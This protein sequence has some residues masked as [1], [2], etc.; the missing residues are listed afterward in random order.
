M[1]NKKH[2]M[3]YVNCNQPLYVDVDD[4]CLKW[5][6][7]TNPSENRVKVECDGFVQYLTP[8]KENIRQLKAH[9]ARGHTVVVWSAGGSSWALAAVKALELESFVDLVTEK[10]MWLLD[11]LQPV[12]FMP[13]ARWYKDE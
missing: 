2:K 9:K 4:T 11:D 8:M 13:K 12:D 7:E 10:P 1:K 5:E 3:I 6:Y